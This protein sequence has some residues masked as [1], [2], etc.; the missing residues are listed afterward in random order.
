MAM[1]DMLSVVPLA[2][3]EVKGDALQRLF[4]VAN[5]LPPQTSRSRHSVPK[6]LKDLAPIGQPVEKDRIGL[7]VRLWQAYRVPY[8]GWI[9]GVLPTCCLSSQHGMLARATAPIA[10]YRD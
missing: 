10:L 4:K 2:Q 9:D 5:L 6:G 3:D 1:H 8:F 7:Q